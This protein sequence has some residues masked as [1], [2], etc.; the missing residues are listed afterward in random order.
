M[1]PIHEYVLKYVYTYTRVVSVG[2][3]VKARDCSAATWEKKKKDL[4]LPPFFFSPSSLSLCARVVP[5]GVDAR[6]VLYTPPSSG[7]V[8][9]RCG[10]SAA[11]AETRGDSSELRRPLHLRVLTRER[12]RERGVVEGASQ[13]EGEREKE[14]DLCC[15]EDIQRDNALRDAPGES[16]ADRSSPSFSAPSFRPGLWRFFALPSLASFPFLSL[17]PLLLA[18]FSQAALL[19]LPRPFHSLFT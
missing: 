5:P 1:V 17:L 4:G 2:P 9:V 14:R 19:S 13:N 15:P 10:R 16:E 7:A 12:E 18:F 11:G 3:R 6:A 8:E